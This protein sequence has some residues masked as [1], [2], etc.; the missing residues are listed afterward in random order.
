MPRLL[1]ATQ[2]RAAYDVEDLDDI[3]HPTHLLHPRDP[4]LS[5]RHVDVNPV[6]EHGNGPER[7]VPSIQ[8]SLLVFLEAVVD[9]QRKRF[10]GVLAVPC[11]I[12]DRH[13]R[14]HIRKFCASPNVNASSPTPRICSFSLH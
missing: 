14:S 4:D 1:W 6:F 11:R 10:L 12:L 5:V 2:M 9:G 3:A 7:A 8:A 13:W